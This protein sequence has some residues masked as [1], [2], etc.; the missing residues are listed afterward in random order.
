MTH[1]DRAECLPIQLHGIQ[2]TLLIPLWARAAE[3]QRQDAIIQDPLA[4]SLMSQIA[5]DFSR[6][7]WSPTL[8]TGIAIR[9]E[10]LDQAVADFLVRF[11]EALVLNLASGLDTRFFR[12][13][14]G[15][16]KWLNVDLPEALA[17]RRQLLQDT[18]RH[19]S[20]AASV[21]T[22]AWCGQVSVAPTQPLLVIIEGLLMYFSP[23]EIRALLCRIAE[24]F[25][26]ARILLECVSPL[27]VWSSG[28]YYRRSGLNVRWRGGIAR[29]HTV[30]SWHPR[31]RCRNEWFYLDR[32]PRRWGWMHLFRQIPALRNTIRILELEVASSQ[33]N[34]SV[35]S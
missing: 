5:Y 18:P 13:D 3:T 16:L 7:N 30:E 29:G 34:V 24:H 35:L 26:G 22:D 8:Q 4:V 25:P 17:L 9:T 15:Q 20:L 2:E 19:Q 32:Y 10:I 33:T 12:L 11:P 31:L 27:S 28:F 1:D 14:N 21:L 6:I 23:A